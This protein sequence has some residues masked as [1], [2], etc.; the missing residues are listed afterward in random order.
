MFG[1]YHW[2]AC[3]FLKGNGREVELWERSQGTARSG[4]RE[5][6]GGD[7]LYERRISNS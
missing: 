1:W 3:P 5:A 2:E 6:S 7:I 4:G